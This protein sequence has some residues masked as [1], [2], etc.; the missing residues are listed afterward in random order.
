MMPSPKIGFSASGKTWKKVGDT[1]GIR[2]KPMEMA[3]TSTLLRCLA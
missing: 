1:I 3:T 2:P